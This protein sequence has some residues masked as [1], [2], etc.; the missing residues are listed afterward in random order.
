MHQ[1]LAQYDQLALQSL[2]CHLLLT[3][4]PASPSM[5]LSKNNNKLSNKSTNSNT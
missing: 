1:P 4:P 5:L 3:H 2:M